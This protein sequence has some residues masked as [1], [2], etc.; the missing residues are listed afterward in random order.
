[1][2]TIAWTNGI[3]GVVALALDGR[4][5]TCHDLDE[6]ADLVARHDSPLDAG[7]A[8]AV[9]VVAFFFALRDFGKGRASTVLDRAARALDA[10]HVAARD[11]ETQANLSE[12]IEA[13]REHLFPIRGG[14]YEDLVQQAYH[15]VRRRLLD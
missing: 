5:I 8:R 14:S 3:S 11:A 1:M 4:Q 2:S 10:A 7:C 15:Y 13:I 6:L 12:G 9:G